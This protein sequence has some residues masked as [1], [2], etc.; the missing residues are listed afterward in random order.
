MWGK[1][2][3]RM[4]HAIA[5]IVAVFVKR[6]PAACSCANRHSIEFVVAI[7]DPENSGMI[8]FQFRLAILLV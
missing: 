5:C 7:E 6:F 1:D 3:A 2:T 4:E 8:K